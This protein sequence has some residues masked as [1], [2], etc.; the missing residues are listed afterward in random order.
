[1]GGFVIRRQIF[2]DCTPATLHRVITDHRPQSPLISP[3]QIN[4]AGGSFNPMTVSIY[5]PHTHHLT[6]I[7]RD[8]NDSFR[9]MY[10]LVE[11][12]HDIGKVTLYLQKS[13]ML[14]PPS[15][16]LDISTCNSRL[17]EVFLSGSLKWEFP[18]ESWW[19]FS[20]NIYSRFSSLTVIF[21]SHARNC[22]QWLLVKI[23]SDWLYFEK[24]L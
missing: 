9:A 15:S 18:S 19:Y 5:S 14:L 20:V 7:G 4:G 2:T 3:W 16:L 6:G 10:G 21:T 12:R 8:I 11:W 13:R 22:N 17:K 23:E 24:G 1:M